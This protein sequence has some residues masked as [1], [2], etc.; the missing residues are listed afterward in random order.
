MSRSHDS[1]IRLDKPSCPIVDL[2]QFLTIPSLL[3]DPSPDETDTG[4]QQ[5]T[6]E[7]HKLE[8][9]LFKGPS[10]VSCSIMQ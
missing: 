10:H 4:M 5:I 3:K 8:E 9:E 7:Q 2:R 1:M 6:A